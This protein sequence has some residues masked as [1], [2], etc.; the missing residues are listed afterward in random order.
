MPRI[1]VEGLKIAGR[2]LTRE[3]LINAIESIRDFSL[4]PGMS[5]I[6]G[7]NDR[8]GLD[9]IYFTRLSHGRF[10]PFNDWHGLRKNMGTSQ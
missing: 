2:N 3:G 7:P 5:I 10:M 4:G 9:T 1:M 6:Y 8:Q